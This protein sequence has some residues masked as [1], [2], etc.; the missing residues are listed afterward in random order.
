MVCR[1]SDKHAC[2]LATRVEFVRSFLLQGLQQEA[3]YFHWESR[4]RLDGDDLADWTWAVKEI[5]DLR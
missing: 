5:P 3:A 2:L 4:G 1:W